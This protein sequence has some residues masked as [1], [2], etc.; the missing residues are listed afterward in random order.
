M[1]AINLASGPAEARLQLGQISESVQLKKKLLYGP[2]PNPFMHS[3][4]CT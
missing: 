1:S 2:T 4:L 3:C